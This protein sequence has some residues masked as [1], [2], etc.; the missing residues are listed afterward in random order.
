MNG[1]KSLQ[2]SLHGDLWLVFPVSWN[3]VP[4]PKQLRFSNK[5]VILRLTTVP[6][7]ENNTVH[8]SS[9]NVE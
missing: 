4:C 8:L 7:T 3:C 5:K 9:T 1:G 2:K 6:N